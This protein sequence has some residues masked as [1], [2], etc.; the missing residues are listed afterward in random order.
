MRMS[1]EFSLKQGMKNILDAEKW[2]DR[3]LLTQ[4]SS[5]N[6]F[7]STHLRGVGVHCKTR[8]DVS[9]ILTQ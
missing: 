5:I 4:S 9:D 3:V 8:G 6:I 7:S 1:E 2:N